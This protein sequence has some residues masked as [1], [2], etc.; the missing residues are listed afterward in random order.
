MKKIYPAVCGKVEI[1]QKNVT[2][3]PILH[4]F[5]LIGYKS[6]MVDQFSNDVPQY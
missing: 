1:F 4:G 2:L 3:R 6:I 5:C